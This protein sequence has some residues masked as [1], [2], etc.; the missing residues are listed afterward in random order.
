MTRPSAD[1][2]VIVTLRPDDVEALLVYCDTILD[3]VT[4]PQ[5]WV[6]WRIR[7]ACVAALT[8]QQGVTHVVDRHLH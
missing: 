8:P 7:Q 2:G 1:E 3:E 5:R 6:W 4:G